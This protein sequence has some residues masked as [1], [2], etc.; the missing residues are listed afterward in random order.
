M[1]R[2]HSPDRQS[3][4][5]VQDD[6]MRGGEG[7]TDEVGKSGIYPA[8]SPDAPGDALIRGEGELVSHRGPHSKPEQDFRKSDLSSGSE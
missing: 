8:S 5:N 3:D 7:R 6:Y 4:Q 1:A 2:E